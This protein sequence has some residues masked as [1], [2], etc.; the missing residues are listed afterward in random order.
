MMNIIN[1]IIDEYNPLVIMRRKKMRKALKNKDVTFL[2]PNCIGGILFHDLGLQFKSP[3]INLMM[4]QTDLLKFVLDME[5]YL[6][7]EFEFFTHEKYTCPCAK[8]DDI[9]VHFTH[10]HTEQDAVDKWNNRV[11]RMNKD[12][13]FVFLTERDGL[14]KEDIEKLSKLDVKGIVVF[15]AN[16]FSD[17][18]YTLQIEKYKKDGEVGNILNKSIINGSREYETYFDFVKWFNEADGKD[19]DISPYIKNV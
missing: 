10:Y 14:K 9:T 12:N 3:T 18:K 19:F 15:T 5:R 4:Y 2:C 11:K 6:K 1:K 7:C 17:I 16:D 8:L 13:I